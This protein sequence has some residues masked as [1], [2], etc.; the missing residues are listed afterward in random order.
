MSKRHKKPKFHPD[1]PGVP[2]IGNKNTPQP[3]QQLPSA[4]PPDPDTICVRVL[5]RDGKRYFA[6]GG[7]MP[8]LPLF[9]MNEAFQPQSRVKHEGLALNGA[10]I[11][12]MV[13][14]PKNAFPSWWCDKDRLFSNVTKNPNDDR[15][16]PDPKLDDV[17]KEN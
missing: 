8:A 7:L 15:L 11:E 1:A 16:E 5:T 14:L 10:D 6:K 2:L 3:G 9:I 12:E 17:A 4:P 13:Q